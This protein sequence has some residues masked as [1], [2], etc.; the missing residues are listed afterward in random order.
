MAKALQ[1]GACALAMPDAM[2]IGGVT[3]WLRAA[4]L[5][6]GS[7]VR[8]PRLEDNVPISWVSIESPI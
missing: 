2:K 5:E 7:G 3:G 6:R 8:V 1:A 4:A